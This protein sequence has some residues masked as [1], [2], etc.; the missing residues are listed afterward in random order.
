MAKH[1]STTQ[2]TEDNDE[3]LH[4]KWNELL[5]EM[6]VM[7]TGAQ[8]LAAFLVVLPFQSRFD[9]LE[10][11][12]ERF[13]L[14]LL[15]ASALVILL[16]ITPVAVHRHFFG[17]QLKATTV[18]LG[19][20]I[21]RVVV[22]GVGVLVAGCVWFVLQVLHGWQTGLI[23]GGILMA[24]ALFLLLILPRIVTPRSTLPEQ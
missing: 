10:V 14:A 22:V 12:D 1:N 17:Q 13:Y 15:V 21:S 18:H 24:A 3:E 20:N 2:K 6:R 4:R 5:Q 16:L 19:H 9:T 23:F 7:Q 11:P 8:I